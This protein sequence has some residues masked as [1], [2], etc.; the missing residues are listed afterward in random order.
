M[1][2]D[3]Q[4]CVE[5]I[6]EHPS[7][8]RQTA[9]L[10]SLTLHLVSYSFFLVINNLLCSNMM[11]RGQKCI[12]ISDYH[13]TMSNQ[14]NPSQVG[15]IVP[16]NFYDNLP[17]LHINSLHLQPS[18]QTGLLSPDEM[19]IPQAACVRHACL[20]AP[21]VAWPLLLPLFS[22]SLFL[23]FFSVFCFWPTS[24]KLPCVKICFPQ[25]FC[26]TRRYMQK[27]IF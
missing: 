19:P 5:P 13:I 16:D 27:N 20:G 24:G 26:I 14:Y 7:T 2:V 8:E 11:L 17:S 22:L 23:S 9:S 15:Y 21:C 12:H 10:P 18:Q 6:I 3:R 4:L 25:Y 1:C